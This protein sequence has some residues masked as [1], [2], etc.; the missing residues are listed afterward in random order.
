MRL[1]KAHG[2]S[3]I[4]HMALQ[5]SNETKVG[6]LTAISITLLVLGFNFLKGN[7]PLKRSQYFY[8]KFEQLDGLVASNPVLMNG[9]MVGTI[10]KTEPSD[11]LLSSIVVSIR[12]TEDIKI[13]ANSVATI[14]GNLLS[15]PAVE[16]TKGDA[17]VFLKNGDTL[18]TR[19]SS[20]FMGAILEQLGPTQQSLNFALKEM[21]TLLKGVNNSFDAQA[22]YNL[23][24]I[25]AH[26]NAATLQLSQTSARLNSLLAGQQNALT[27]TIGNLQATSEQVK[28]GTQ[29][30]PAITANLE[31]TTQKLAAVDLATT[32]Q[33]L[34]V[35][36][37][38]VKSTLDTLGSEQGTIGALM[39]DRRLYD[40]LSSTVNSVNLLL[41][42]L[43]LHPKRYVNVSVFGKKDKSTPLMKPMQEDSA[44][45]EQFKPQQ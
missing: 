24:Q 30:L 9:L 39:H 14:K 6:A 18:A 31:T 11:N 20:G 32:V 21:D 41:Q 15:T 19:E 42:D 22:Q 1:L 28:A 45:Q 35:A 37:R 44:T 13:P 34:D 40:N 23:Q 27:T 36:L 17:Q 16:I 8:A 2:F 26:V 29:N 5:I 10:Y 4:L 7:N 25:L 43:R 33:N 38:Q 12:L 3:L